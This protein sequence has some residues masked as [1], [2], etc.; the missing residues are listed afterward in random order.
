MSKIPAP[1]PR[2][3]LAT[4]GKFIPR[5][6]ATTTAAAAAPANNDRQSPLNVADIKDNTEDTIPQAAAP[7]NDKLEKKS[8]ED[9]LSLWVVG[10]GK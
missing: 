10:Y 8:L 7:K 6:S 4:S 9:E 1:P 3:S 5:R 2:L